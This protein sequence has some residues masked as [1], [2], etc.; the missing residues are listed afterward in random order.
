MSAWW[1]AI[2]VLQEGP[3]GWLLAS[4]KWSWKLGSQRDLNKR[5]CS[6]IMEKRKEQWPRFYFPSKL[7]S[8]LDFRQEKHWRAPLHRL[9]LQ[10]PTI[11]WLPVIFQYCFSSPESML[12]MKFLSNL[13]VFSKLSFYSGRSGWWSSVLTRPITDFW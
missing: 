2:P 12:C 3:V 7:K 9:L 11:P 10:N 4:L 6:G 5:R 8:K 1:T 13:V